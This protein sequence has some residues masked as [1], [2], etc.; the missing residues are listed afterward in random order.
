MKCAIS[1]RFN[2]T[3]QDKLHKYFTANNTLKYTNVVYDIVTS[4]NNRY[5]PAIGMPPSNTV[6][7]N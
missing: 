3:L 7:H 2:R 5:H 1:E 6:I 4:I